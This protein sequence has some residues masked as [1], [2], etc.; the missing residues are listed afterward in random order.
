MKKMKLSQ[1]QP[2]SR[3][4]SCGWL[5][6]S[7]LF[8]GCSHLYYAEPN[9]SNPFVFPG[10][11]APP[12]ALAQTPSPAG[13]TLAP[14]GAAPMPAPGAPGT[15]VPMPPPTL[16]SGVPVALPNSAQSSPT[17]GKTISDTL[18]IGDALTVSFSD[19]P[20]PG[21]Q[22]V[23]QR[24]GNDGNI[25]LPFN[26]K[27]PAVGRTL[28]QL[29]DDIR[30]AYVPSIFKQITPSVISEDRVFYVEGE[31]KSPNRYPY[32]GE[33]TVLRA[34]TSSGGLTDFSNRKNIE[35]RRATG[36]KLIINWNKA[37]KDSKLDPPVYP[38]DQIIVK[39]RIW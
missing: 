5:L 38:N 36:Q 15:P 29:Q 12:N 2:R 37:T 4:L 11:G 6:A 33:M 1:T 14:V 35:L 27:L 19:I 23:S 20:G 8:A 3:L 24:I 17:F 34:I 28:A 26:V 10:Q 32:R 39:K 9:P 7:L 13:G 21:L 31:V 16:A 18:G 25:Y 22:P 30:N